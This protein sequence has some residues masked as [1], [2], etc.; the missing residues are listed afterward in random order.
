MIKKL[1][2]IWQEYGFE[3]C[4]ISCLFLLLL[5]YFLRGK[6]RGTW[7]KNFFIPDFK[8]KK[9][10]V[11][12]EKNSK[13]E[14]E[15]RRV[16]E[17]IF[18]VPFEKSRPNFLKNPALG[19]NNLELDC[20]NENLKLAVEYNGIQHYKYVPFF[21]SS[22]EAFQNQKYRDYIKRELCVKNNI[23]LIEVPHYIEIDK[24]K[25]FIISEL[26]KKNIL[27]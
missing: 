3:I 10:D 27:K 19:Q 2:K 25:N 12:S 8:E 9:L 1:K 18:R 7:S 26:I 16:L 17:E 5:S 13:G 23:T 4:F 15:C 24:I 21:H 6:K 22:K 11:K 20:F 14:N